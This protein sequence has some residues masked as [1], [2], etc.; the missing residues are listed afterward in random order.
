MASS[1]LPRGARSEDEAH[2]LRGAPEPEAGGACVPLAGARADRGGAPVSVVLR[3]GPEPEGRSSPSG[4]SSRG[5]RVRTTGSVSSAD[6]QPRPLPRRLRRG[7]VGA[8][9]AMSSRAWT[10]SDSSEAK[11]TSSPESACMTSAFRAMN[12]R[13]AWSQARLGATSGEPRWASIDSRATGCGS[14][15]TATQPAR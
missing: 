13:N 14:L 5:R 12:A 9:A 10:R 11:R 2:R 4:S 1:S 7:P 3:R 8:T 15:E 6:T